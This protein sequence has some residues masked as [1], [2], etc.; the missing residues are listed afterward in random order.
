MRRLSEA[1]DDRDSSVG[2]RR[3]WTAEH[4]ELSGELAGTIGAR[5]AGGAELLD[6]A[7]R[8][9]DPPDGRAPRIPTRE[10]RGTDLYL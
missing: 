7:T 1:I 10:D 8:R 5:A 9:S 4:V 3:H 6:R 2:Q